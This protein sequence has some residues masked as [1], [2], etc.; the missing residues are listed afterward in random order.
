MSKMVKTYD[1][2]TKQTTTIPMKE[3]APGM[4]EAEVVGVGRVW[5]DSKDVKPPSSVRHEP[6]APE[7][8]DRIAQIKAALDEVHP[9]SLKEWEDGFRQDMH[10]EREIAL[11]E[12]VAA[13]YQRFA[14]D[15]S[16]SSK[17]RQ[18]YFKVILG[19]TLSPRAAVLEVVRLEAITRE[20]AQD[21]ITLFF[22]GG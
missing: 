22:D 19:C 3:L 10:P 9:M 13:V 11:W 18:D 8:R 15:G 12:R 14:E 6:F 21:A 17:Q 7:L 20:Q 4:M 16:V 5:I 2:K 1:I